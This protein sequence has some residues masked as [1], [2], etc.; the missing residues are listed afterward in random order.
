VKEYPTRWSDMEV[1][2]ELGIEQ[3]E[4]HHL[5]EACDVLREPTDLFEGHRLNTHRI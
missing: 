3:R 1:R 2:E 5:F 4:D